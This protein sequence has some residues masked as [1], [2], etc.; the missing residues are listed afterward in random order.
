MV[1]G[2]VS[3]VCWD[4]IEGFLDLGFFSLLFLLLQGG[5]KSVDH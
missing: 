1:A 3:I 2:G 5:I 4:E